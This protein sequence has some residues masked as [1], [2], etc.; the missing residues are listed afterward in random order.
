[1]GP[2]L[3]EPSGLTVS[4]QAARFAR[5]ANLLVMGQRLQE[6]RNNIANTQAQLQAAAPE[7]RALFEETLAY[8]RQ[9]ERRQLYLMGQ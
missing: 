3:R 8:F 9:Q 7:N 4:E 2:V 6:I 5:A 1:M